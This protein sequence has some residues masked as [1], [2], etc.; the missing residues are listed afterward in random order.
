M[1]AY[2]IDRSHNLK[3]GQIIELYKNNE[4]NL[5]L[6]TTMFPNS[7]CYDIISNVNFLTRRLLLCLHNKCLKV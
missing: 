7:L 5:F 4:D 2:H 3:E 1:I 6:T